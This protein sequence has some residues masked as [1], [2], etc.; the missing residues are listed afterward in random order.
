MGKV[1]PWIDS[2][3]G[4]RGC[5]TINYPKRNKKMKEKIN[6]FILAVANFFRALADKIAALF[7]TK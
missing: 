1:I 7:I 3:T 2:E 6:T 5:V 4:H